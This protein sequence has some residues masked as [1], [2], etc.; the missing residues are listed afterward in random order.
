M[1]VC[2]NLPSQCCRLLRSGG[3]AFRLALYI[4]MILLSFYEDFFRYYI[5]GYDT[6]N[7]FHRHDIQ[8]DCERPLQQKC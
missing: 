4:T 7:I 1:L 8:E 2:N 3:D 5:H 6:Q